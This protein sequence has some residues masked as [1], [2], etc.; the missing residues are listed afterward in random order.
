MEAGVLGLREIARVDARNQARRRH[1]RLQRSRLGVLGGDDPDLRARLRRGI[2]AGR[3]RL[4]T[5]AG[6]GGRGSSGA[7]L[8]YRAVR[9]PRR[10]RPHHLQQDGRRSRH[11]RA[12]EPVV[13]QGRQECALAVPGGSARGQRGDV[14]AANR[15]SLLHA[16]P[17]HQ[18]GGGVLSGRSQSGDLRHRRTVAPD[19]RPARRSYQQQMGQELPRQSVEGSA[20]ARQDS[21]SRLHARGRR[22]GHRDGDVAR[23]AR[24]ARRQG[25]RGLSLLH[26]AGVEH[27]SRPYHSGKPPK[28]RQ[29]QEVDKPAVKHKRAAARTKVQSIRS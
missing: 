19:L 6:A 18:E 15:A 2:S 14:S 3:R 10:I 13:R 11:D 17:R 26:R 28:A 9:H 1:H 8:A 21:A 16:W 24:R 27:R 7:C 12:D 29:A 23:H 4:G 20:E 5:A 22:R 25:R